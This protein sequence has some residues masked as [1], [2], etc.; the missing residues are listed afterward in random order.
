[1]DEIFWILFMTVNS[2][3]EKLRELALLMYYY[4][5]L[6]NIVLTLSK[7]SLKTRSVFNTLKNTLEKFQHLMNTLEKS[8]QHYKK[9]L[10]KIQNYKM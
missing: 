5:P 6:T 2:I 7:K 1:M 10:F 8:S 3:W 9:W 4:C